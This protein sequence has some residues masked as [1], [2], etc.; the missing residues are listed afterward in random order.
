MQPESRSP[1]GFAAFWAQAWTETDSLSYQLKE[2]QVQMSEKPLETGCWLDFPALAMDGAGSSSA[3]GYAGTSPAR[4]VP[5]EWKSITPSLREQT[6]KKRN[7][8]KSCA[9]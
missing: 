2:G 7:P 6:K 8:V 1:V 3:C 9:Q 4:E 5:S